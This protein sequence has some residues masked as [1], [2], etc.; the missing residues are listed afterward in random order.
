MILWSWSWEQ[1][2]HLGF[3]PGK[4]QLIMIIISYCTQSHF[5]WFSDDC[6][7]N[8][9]IMNMQA[10]IMILKKEKGGG[11]GDKG[12]YS[13]RPDFLHQLPLR[14][15]PMTNDHAGLYA[16]PHALP[17]ISSISRPRSVVARS[18]CVT[19]TIIKT[20]TISVW[21]HVHVHPRDHLD[22][23]SSS[24]DAGRPWQCSPKCSSSCAGF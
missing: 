9:W 24:Q 22:Q 3:C 1:V 21:M 11:M 4:V 18:S 17:S 20:M 19:N 15:W 2:S 13:K 14:W 23:W 5:H 6:D 10:C 8:S 16:A 12:L 7:D